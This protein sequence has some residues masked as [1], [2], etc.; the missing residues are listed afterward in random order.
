VFVEDP[1]RGLHRVG[2][3]DAQVEVMI[4]AAGLGDG[5]QGMYG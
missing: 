2:G 5:A 1:W 4:A 3:D